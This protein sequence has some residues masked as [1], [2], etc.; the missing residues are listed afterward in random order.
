MERAIYS[1][2]MTSYLMEKKIFVDEP[3][4]LV[5]VGASGGIDKVW[6][7]FGFS[8]N[9]VGFEPLMTEC[10]RL[11]ADKNKHENVTYYPYLITSEDPLVHAE[12]GPPSIGNT[13]VRTS[14]NKGKEI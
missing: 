2:P 13:F 12:S 11:N 7:I 5:D 6:D 9:A 1:P 8:F 10:E 3:F 4:C 14:A